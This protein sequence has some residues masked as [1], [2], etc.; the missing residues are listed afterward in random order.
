VQAKLAVILKMPFTAGLPET[1]CGAGSTLSFTAG[2][3]EELPRLLREFE[4]RTLLD[5]PCG[6]FNWMS[7]TDLSD[8]DYIGADYDQVHCDWTRARESDPSRFRPRSKKVV[9]LDIFRDLLPPADLM[10]C[11][12]FLQHLPNYLV[13]VVLNNFRTS[14]ISWLLATSHNNEQNADIEKSGMFRPL[15]LMIAPFNLP[16]PHRSIADGDG[17][18]LGLW[19]RNDWN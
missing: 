1:G 3:R 14:G 16:S 7:R 10:L 2:I 12:D 8:V 11:R 19:H 6:D 13:S 18:I 17:R 4:V 15:N 9:K 5:A